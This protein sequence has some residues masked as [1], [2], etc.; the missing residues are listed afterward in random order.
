MKKK[1]KNMKISNRHKK[2]FDNITNKMKDVININIKLVKTIEKS[3][4]IFASL[5]LEFARL[6][7]KLAEEENKKWLTA[8]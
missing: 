7:N 2:D 3:N 4:I 6:Q 5:V 1:E 8:L